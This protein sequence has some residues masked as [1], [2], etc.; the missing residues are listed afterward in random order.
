MV[1]NRKPSEA[2]LAAAA[3]RERENGAAR[4]KVQVPKLE[5][6]EI[7]IEERREG[8]GAAETRHVRRFVLANAPAMFDFP[9]SDRSCT[10]GGHD[11]TREI[12]MSLVALK[13]HFEGDHHC[14]SNVSPGSCARILRYVATAT[15]S[16]LVMRNRTRG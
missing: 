11:L 15:L 13:T 10:S 7:A 1:S 16:R 14:G 2:S 8:V 4:L 3:R 6:L 9:C 12:M 5:T